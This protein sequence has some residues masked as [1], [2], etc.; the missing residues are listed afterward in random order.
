VAIDR[1]MRSGKGGRKIS[2]SGTTEESA[3]T[4]VH[5]KMNVNHRKTMY[6]NASR[7]NRKY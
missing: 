4:K 1:N 2:V 3:L 7:P 6:K 5:L